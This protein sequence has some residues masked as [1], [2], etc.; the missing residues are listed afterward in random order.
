MTDIQKA[1]CLIGGEWVEGHGEFDRL[2]PFTGRAVA[3]V[4]Q[5]RRDQVAS[6]VAL[7][8]EAVAQELA[9]RD[10]ARI[11]VQ[12]RELLSNRRLA[13]LGVMIAEGGFSRRDIEGEI[14]RALETLRFCAEE[15]TRLVGH[16]IPLQGSLGQEDRLAFTIR[17][18]VG[19]VCAITPFNS[20]LNAVIHKIVPALAAG[21]AVVLKPSPRTP[22]T[23]VLLC[24]LLL[25]A[26]LPPGL[27]ALLHGDAELG[28][29]LLEEQRIAYYSFTG[30]TRVGRIIHAGAGLRR[31]H[32]ELGSIACTVVCKDADLDVAI[33]KI[34][35]ASFRRAGQ[36]CTSIQRLYVAKPVL[37]DVIER[38]AAGAAALRVGDPRSADTDVGPMITETE[39]QRAESWV[40]EARTGGAQVLAGGSRQGAVLTPTVLAD[41]APGM[42]VI[43]QE[44]F[45]PVVS[46]IGFD[47]LT[48]TFAAINSLPYGLATGIFSASLDVAI[49]AAHS[50]RV[51]SVHINDLASSRTDSMPYGGVKESGHGFEGP[52]YA[53]LEMTEERV[54][55]FRPTRS[56]R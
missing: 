20:P 48:E 15:A 16:I 37:Q 11:F 44:I 55:T 56:S 42:K 35:G 40:A 36:F 27:L 8:L 6:A 25:D 31:T 19:V 22:M 18:P 5:A 7:G 12:A 39:A 14:D 28:T 10:L 23:A 51:G 29:W 21:N 52:R 30:S 2:D 41:V 9:A 13:F 24:Q 46:A 4:S 1:H 53:M 34:I 38:V 47:D 17:K 49:Q 50:L 54:V 43:D 26:G 32:L 33:P 45:A 3:R